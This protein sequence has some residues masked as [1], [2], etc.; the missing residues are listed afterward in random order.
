MG[1]NRVTSSNY[2]NRILNGAVGS[3]MIG[4]IFAIGAGAAINVAIFLWAPV[5]CSFGEVHRFEKELGSVIAVLPQITPANATMI[6]GL[7]SHFLGYRHAGY[8]LPGYLTIQF[9]EVRLIS[10]TRVF[11][12]QSRDTQVEASLPDTSAGEFVLFPL[13]LGDK[14][15]SDHMA[16]VRNRFPPG[17]LRTVVRGGH[18]FTMGRV[19][20]LRILFPDAC[21]QP[22][23]CEQKATDLSTSRRH[24]F[25]TCTPTD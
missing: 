25:T 24:P 18:E 15:Y 10:G 6:V 7:D 9:P 17:H 14:E 19:A 8:Y 23:A 2:G 11:T 22:G 13:P 1:K 16:S 20:D 5:Y 3:D 4:K 12:M 21:K